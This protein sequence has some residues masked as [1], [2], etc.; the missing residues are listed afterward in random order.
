MK[1][2]LLPL[3]LALCYFHP[4][5]CQDALNETQIDA[6]RGA[7]KVLLRLEPPDHLTG[8]LQAKSHLQIRL[9][10]HMQDLYEKYAAEKVANGETV[11]SIEPDKDFVPHFKDVLVYNL[12]SV[13]SH[14]EKIKTAQLH[15]FRRKLFPQKGYS[16]RKLLPPPCRVRLYQILTAPGPSPIQPASTGDPL[17]VSDIERMKLRSLDTVPVAQMT[18]GGWY[19]IEISMALKEM[20]N[21]PG[22]TSNF[23]FGVRFEGPRGK[24]ITPQHFLKEPEVNIS[25]SY[26]M[27]FS[28]D[29]S[30]SIDAPFNMQKLND[31]QINIL[32]EMLENASVDRKLSKNQIKKN[33]R[34]TKKTSYEEIGRTESI[35]HGRKY[36]GNIKSN[37]DRINKKRNRTHQPVK[38]LGGGDISELVDYDNVKKMIATRRHNHKSV[39]SLNLRYDTATKSIVQKKATKLEEDEAQQNRTRRVRSIYDNYIIEF[40][41]DE[42]TPEPT[43]A[44]DLIKAVE[45]EKE[46][47][48]GD[49]SYYEPDVYMHETLIPPSY[50]HKYHNNKAKMQKAWDLDTNL[51]P[52]GDASG[53]LDM[54]W[55]DVGEGS[56]VTISGLDSLSP[57]EGSGSSKSRRKDKRRHKNQ[58]RKNRR[59]QK[60]I[61]FTKSHSEQDRYD[62]MPCRKI[63]LNVTFHELGWDDWIIAPSSF[64][65]GICSGSCHSIPNRNFTNHAI[66]QS[67]VSQMFPNVPKPCCVPGK[68]AP[69]TMLIVDSSNSV[70]LRKFGSMEVETCECR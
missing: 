58:K 67:L 51:V 50:R 8:D 43:T 20:L 29:A 54:W 11:R 22:A 38:S 19:T 47:D 56:G 63:P 61:Q 48:M 6:L 68:M 27:I 33:N 3:L 37:N 57:A 44:E 12:S 9:P 41:G 59:M 49:L 13:G 42:D 25:S 21:S 15:I 52:D 70:V 26:L 7:L 2:A 24:S 65:F 5:S 17:E 4:A 36:Y 55:Y 28:E 64:E 16:R 31:N 40:T 53:D 45:Y 23:I 14:L 39:N 32:A 34:K 60:K 62:T 30:A 35:R 46:D 1:S 69:L 10:K 66:V 18:R